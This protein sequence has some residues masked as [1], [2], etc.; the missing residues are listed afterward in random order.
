MLLRP[1]K[2]SNSNANHDEHTKCVMHRLNYSAR[3]LLTQS[4]LTV[5]H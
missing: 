4:V 5:R 2:N 1:A 3:S